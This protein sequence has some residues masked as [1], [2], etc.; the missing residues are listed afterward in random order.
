MQEKRESNHLRWGNIFLVFFVNCIISAVQLQWKQKY[1]YI[2]TE[3]DPAVAS[4]LKTKPIIELRKGI[5]DFIPANQSIGLCNLLY[6]S[7]V[8]NINDRNSFL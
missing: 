3:F 5:L 6:L 4:N 1:F 8:F 2:R 7:N